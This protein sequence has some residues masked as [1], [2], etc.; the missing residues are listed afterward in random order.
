MKN[1]GAKKC[2][3]DDTTVC[4]YMYPRSRSPHAKYDFEAG[5]NIKN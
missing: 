5:E 1:F 3:F 2:H 4:H